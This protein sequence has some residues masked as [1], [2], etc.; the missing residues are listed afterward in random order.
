M[1]TWSGSFPNVLFLLIFKWRYSNFF[2]SRKIFSTNYNAKAPQNRAVPAEAGK[3]SKNQ[4]H[5]CN[6][7]SSHPSQDPLQISLKAT[8]LV[9][10]AHFADEYEINE[11]RT[12]I[13]LVSWFPISCTLNFHHHA[14]LS[15]DTQVSFGRH[16]Q[17]SNRE[18]KLFTEL[19]SGK[20][21]LINRIRYFIYQN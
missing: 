17:I 15:I 4:N 8:H 20:E 9:Q 3:D 16:L 5:A 19:I 6:S 18:H 14:F 1:I 13:F 7:T 11:I 10:F 21:E 2:F 12:A